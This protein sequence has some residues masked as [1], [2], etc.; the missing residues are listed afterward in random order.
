VSGEHEK[1][2]GWLMA[3]LLRLD[4][5]FATRTACW[6]TGLANLYWFWAYTLSPSSVHP[7]FAWFTFGMAV[8]AFHQLLLR[9][10]RAGR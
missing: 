6:V 8:G 3:R 4:A 10:D 2:P 7:V 9:A 1:E 5:F